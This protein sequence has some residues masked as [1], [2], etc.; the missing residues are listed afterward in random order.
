MEG[1]TVNPF[2]SFTAESKHFS[3]FRRNGVTSLPPSP[4]DHRPA[5]A[6]HRQPEGTFTRP[7]HAFLG[8]RRNGADGGRFKCIHP[9]R[10]RPPP[11]I[12]APSRVWCHSRGWRTTKK[13]RAAGYPFLNEIR[14][15]GSDTTRPTH[16]GTY[17]YYV[18]RTCHAISPRPRGSTTMPLMQ[19]RGGS[20]GLLQCRAP[21]CRS[22][23]VS[24][25]EY[26]AHTHLKW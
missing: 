22:M 24:A 8:G 11:L 13:M 12:S 7:R 15:F 17:L 20:S 26:D 10:V 16:K 19:I 5:A 14:V 25:H 23:I 1:R 6:M 3:T 2:P 4:P 18:P 9:V 21:S